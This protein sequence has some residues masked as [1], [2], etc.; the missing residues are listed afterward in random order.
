[1]L[2]MVSVLVSAATIDNAIAHQG[3]SAVSQKIIAQRTLP[4]AKTQSKERDPSQVQRD[5]GEINF[6]QTHAWFREP[7]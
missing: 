2:M 5:N 3:M 1:M 6:V 4:F 7:K